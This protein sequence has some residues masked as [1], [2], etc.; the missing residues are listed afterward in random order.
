M[1][2]FKFGGGCIQ[3]HQGIM[4]MARIL[5]DHRS[6]DVVV[7]VSALGKTTNK[8][9][10]LA[11]ATF[12]RSDSVSILMA[13]LKKHH[14][15]VINDL[16]KS[17]GAPIIAEVDA[18]FS[19]LENRNYGEKPMD[20]DF[21]YDQV[22]AIGEM[23]SS[24][25]ISAYLKAEGF[26][27]HWLDVREVIRTD[28][29]YREANVDWK[30]T[31]DLMTEK[32]PALLKGHIVITQGFLGGTTENL[33]TTLGREGSDYSAA[34]FAYVLEAKDVVIWK[35]VPGVLN[36]DP[37]FFDDSVPFDQ[38]SYH[39]AIEMTYY[40]AKV[41]HPKTIIP[42]Q[43]KKIPLYVRPF[44][45]PTAA[46]T[47][48]GHKLITKDIP[49]VKVLKRNQVLL[50]ISP[51]DFSFM[52]E[53]SIGFIYTLFAKHRIRINLMQN[54]AISLS[55]CSNDT[56]RIDLLMED[57]A[58]KFKVLRN[59]GLE[60]LTIRHYNDNLIEKL[61][62]GKELLLEQKSRHTIQLLFSV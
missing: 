25:I 55:V 62:K 58:Q 6:G 3:D 49:P 28:N 54:S 36:A 29:T 61:S 22:V 15:D 30:V 59:D 41:I 40:G 52:T 10:K 9:E 14:V 21:V 2:V 42:L 44:N 60:L 12:K 32:M 43:N 11:E 51:Y 35:D 20:Y 56:K 27:T 8:L 57:L 17:E 45:D 18:L 39:E 26:S 13:D 33:T 23:L 47:L 24:K 31:T 19:K 46:G 37:R 53:D 38:L 34:I 5:E 1:K 50:S 4:R 48:I 7:V 16:F